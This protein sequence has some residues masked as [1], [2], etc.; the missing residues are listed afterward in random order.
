[1]PN[2]KPQIKRLDKTLLIAWIVIYLFALAI[3]FA[4]AKMTDKKAAEDAIPLLLGAP[5][6]I[7][8][9]S[10][11]LASGIHWIGWFTGTPQLRSMKRTL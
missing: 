8:L 6:G 9:V 5:L 7:V 1:M 10:A 4:V 3:F 2:R 11:L